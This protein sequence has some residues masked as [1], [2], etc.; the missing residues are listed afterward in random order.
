MPRLCARPCDSGDGER[1]SCLDVCQRATRGG[2]HSPRDLHEP[3]V[4]V[5]VPDV[6]TQDELARGRE[7]VKNVGD[8]CQR[9][10]DLTI[11]EGARGGAQLLWKGRQVRKRAEFDIEPL[12][13]V[14]VGELAADQGI[15]PVLKGESACVANLCHVAVGPE[16]DRR[17]DPFGVAALADQARDL[18][19]APSLRE[20]TLDA[21]SKSS[22]HPRHRVTLPDRGAARGDPDRGPQ[23]SASGCRIASQLL[24]GPT[25][26]RG[27]EVPEAPSESDPEPSLGS[28]AFDDLRVAG[29]F[30][31]VVLS[32]V[33][34][35][36]G[37]DCTNRLVPHRRPGGK[38]TSP[39]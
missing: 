10:G 23:R 16:N 5:E 22:R 8:V 12:A 6:D 3:A 25:P 24:A 9:P 26:L 4:V 20:V 35:S 30:E 34:T 33:P 31:V 27:L 32:R 14:S 29:R 36:V 18:P 7:G 2:S 28:L 11:R 1:A 19:R 39:F 17:L 38:V 21:L 15:A 13:P 37:V